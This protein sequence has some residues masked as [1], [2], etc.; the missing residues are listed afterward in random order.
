[1]VELIFSFYFFSI[2]LIANLQFRTLP[3]QPPTQ[4]IN[5]NRND[6]SALVSVI[7]SPSTFMSGSVMGHHTIR[8]STQSGLVEA[9]PTSMSSSFYPVV[10]QNQQ[11]QALSIN[12][13]QHQQYFYGWQTM[14][15]VSS[16][17]PSPVVPPSILKQSINYQKPPTVQEQ[18]DENGCKERRDVTWVSF[19]LDDVCL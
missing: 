1:M 14:S 10:R 13:S 19:D 3:R 5:V 4:H 6:S 2:I 11:P 9:V 7:P 18:C 16:A 15:P 12:T 17:L 8:R